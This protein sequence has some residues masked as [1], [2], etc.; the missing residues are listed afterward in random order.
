MNHSRQ[1]YI[2]GDW[3]APSTS[4]TLAVVDPATETA[5]VEIAMGAKADVDRAVTAARRAFESF[6]QTS[7]AE[8]VA[9]LQK[10]VAGFEARADELARTISREMGAPLPFALS[11]QVGSGPNHIKEMIRVLERFEFN[12]PHDRT[13]IAKEPIGVCALITPWNWPINQI[14]CKVAPALAAGC[15]MVL[16]PSEIAPLSAI[17]FAEILHDAGV[18]AGVFN[19]VNGDGPEVG[20]ALAGHP[21]V[22]MVSI[23]GSTRAGVLVAKAAAETVKRVAQ[24]LG[25]KSPNILLPDA[26][27]KRATELGVARCF[28]NTG[29]SCSAAT[30]LLVPAERH[31]EIAGYA[32]AAAATFVTGAPDQEG[33]TLGPLVNAAQFDKVQLLIEKGI[34]EG[35]TLVT[36]GPGRPEGLERGYYVRPTVFANVRPD[37]AI[38]REEIF[39]PVLVIIPYRD[40]DEA[41]A[42]ANDTPYGL[43][44]YVQGGD[45][46]RARRVARRIRAGNVHINYPPIDRGA[47]FGGYKQSGNGREWG[48]W[49]LHEFLE[50]K[51]IM[52][53]QA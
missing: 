52:G 26:D 10:I 3:V 14:V 27:M 38:A 7:R 36:G 19:L 37:M 8:R 35:A 33:T 23:T 22:D 17:I 32:K 51:A 2:D 16:K 29:Q 45:L 47:P 6:S 28:S 4:R 43:S 13:M 15:T 39:G 46:D 34:A 40:E 5:F 12:A 1:F 25:G 42:I 30:R 31:D 20:A 24:E 21:D 49:G 18:P 44:A 48:A 50:I 41:V 11:A 53:Y 9:L